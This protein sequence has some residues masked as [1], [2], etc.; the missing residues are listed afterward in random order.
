MP[1]AGET[2]FRRMSSVQRAHPIVYVLMMVDMVVVVPI[3]LTQGAT[4]ALV[5]FFLL[6]FLLAVI[7]LGLFV[8]FR[9]RLRTVREQLKKLPSVEAGI[10][11][12]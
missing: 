10:E 8:H 2:G 7:A 9:R 5:V 11:K 1:S 6:Q 3:V 12:E 4:W